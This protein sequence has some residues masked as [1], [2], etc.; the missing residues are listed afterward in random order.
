MNTLDQQV[1][2]ITGSARGLG[3]AIAIELAK[4]GADIVISDISLDNTSEV[5]NEIK[6]IGRK[7]I[8]VPMDVTDKASVD[9]GLAQAL[10]VFPAISILV[11][12]A[13]VLNETNG[14]DATPAQFDQCIGVNLKGVWLVSNAIKAHLQS[15][16]TGKIINIASVGARRG[17]A[18]TPI[19]N[20]SKAAVISMTQ[21]FSEE[22]GPGNINV[23]A[24]CPGFTMASATGMFE[25]FIRENK[26]DAET[27][28]QQILA[29]Q[30]IKREQSGED[31]GR[32]VVFLASEQASFISG[33]ALNVDG[34]V[35]A[36]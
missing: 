13:G 19:Y 26:M 7:V 30:H 6:A 31:I 15:Q 12:N 21:A 11:N 14:E 22:L 28:R 4:D 24:I 25:Y 10:Q 17:S 34:G 9:H 16:S 5:V 32:A 20:A 3:K 36:N 8:A 27:F 18:G 1:A 35:C 33:Q 23:N 29:Q 2:L